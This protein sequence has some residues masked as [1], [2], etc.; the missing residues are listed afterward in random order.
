MNFRNST[1]LPAV[2]GGLWGHADREEAAMEF[3]QNFWFAVPQP[4][5][6]VKKK[7]GSLLQVFHLI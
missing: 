1:A 2:P 7:P 5:S 6:T 3:D 4:K